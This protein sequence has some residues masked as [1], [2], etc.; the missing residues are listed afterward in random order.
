MDQ[1]SSFYNTIKHNR[2]S[3]YLVLLVIFLLLFF[4]I[5]SR[6]SLK[7][8]GNP[9]FEIKEINTHNKEYIT[10]LGTYILPFIA[11]ETKTVYDIAAYIILFITMGL[12]YVR[13]NLI[14]TNPMLLFFGYDLFEVIDAKNNKLVCISK[15]QF[16]S[17]DKPIGIKLGENTYIISKWKKEN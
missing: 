12:I 2:T 1:F 13:T 15:D 10:Y 4:Y 7:A 8:Q 9:K 17:G 11:L 16:K 14:Y 6:I 3:I 5:Y